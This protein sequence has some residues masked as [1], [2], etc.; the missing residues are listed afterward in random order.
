MKRLALLF[1]I[2]VAVALL[3]TPAW[4]QGRVSRAPRPPVVI[5][6]I[7]SDAPSW[8]RR[9]GCAELDAPSWMRTGGPP[10]RYLCDGTADDVQWQAAINEAE[11]SSEPATLYVSPGTYSWASP[12]YV[13]YASGLTEGTEG[14]S[15]IGQ[16]KVEITWNGATVGDC[17]YGKWMIQ[18]APSSFNVNFNLR[19][20]TLKCEN[21]VNGVFIHN[22]IRG[23]V[24]DIQIQRPRYIGLLSNSCWFGHYSQISI[25]NAEGMGALFLRCNTAIIDRL[26]HYNA[27]PGSTGDTM[28]EVFNYN[29]STSS[30]GTSTFE[31][32]EVLTEADGG[33]QAIFLGYGAQPND[34][35][36]GRIVVAYLDESAPDEFDNGQEVEG[37]TSGGTATLRITANHEGYDVTSGIYITSQQF[38]L[39]NVSLENLDYDSDPLL[40]IMANTGRVSNV[41]LE[42]SATWPTGASENPAEILIQLD[43]CRNVVVENVYGHAGNNYQVP[44]NA[45]DCDM[46]DD[47]ATGTLNSMVPTT[48]GDRLVA[49]DSVYIWDGVGGM[50]DAVY[51]VSAADLTDTSFKVDED[52]GANSGANAAF[53]Y[54][55]T[56]VER[57]SPATIVHMEE[58]RGCTV[59]NLNFRGCR[60]S[61]VV[62]DVDC[63]DCTVDTVRDFWVEEASQL[64]Q[65]DDYWLAAPH[66]TLPVNDLGTRSVVRN[67]QLYDP[68]ALGTITYTGIDDDVQVLDEVDGNA[69]KTTLMLH[70]KQM[71]IDGAAVGFGSEQIFTFPVGN[72]LVTGVVVDLVIDAT[73]QY[74]TG[75]TIDD[76]ANGDFSCGTT[77]TSDATLDS[78]DVDL[79]AKT[80]I[81]QLSSGVGPVDGPLVPLTPVSFNGTGGAKEAHISV[82]I[83]NVDISGSTTI[84]L[85]GPVVIHWTFLGDY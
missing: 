30:G 73:S 31:P 27:T 68:Y 80:D 52:P 79:A 39:R 77:G 61:L 26:T 35:A 55:I 32:L 37:G 48:F 21:K 47:G 71:S 23:N 76:D 7:A 6:V 8:M 85:R 50:T 84:A 57:M 51:T 1:A 75:A 58:S 3:I 74:D 64:G 36:N 13:G 60:T 54:A 46:T 16:G 40:L 45:Y 22:I 20:L 15:I 28:P 41:Y 72:I 78:T 25:V 5:Q 83:D 44:A 29:W 4:G 53:V 12:V 18:V 24:K 9:V 59:R 65:D 42:Q 81:A 67:L 38:L 2:V 14:C 43:E 69:H 56:N 82:L 70:N 11:A 49:G 19:G 63:V 17:G 33:E 10:S 62:V 66:P 34:T